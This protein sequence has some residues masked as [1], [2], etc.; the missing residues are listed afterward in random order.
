MNILKTI[1]TTLKTKPD[2]KNSEKTESLR[3]YLGVINLFF[4]EEK[5]F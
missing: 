1:N 4:L 3:L 2:L 5:N